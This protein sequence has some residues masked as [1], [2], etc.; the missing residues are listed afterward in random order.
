MLRVRAIGFFIDPNGQVEISGF[1]SATEKQYRRER[2]RD[3]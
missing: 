2:R 3:A 1:E